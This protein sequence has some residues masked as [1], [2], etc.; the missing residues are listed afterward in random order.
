[1]KFLLNV[2][3]LSF[4]AVYN[5]LNKLLSLCASG[6]PPEG[7]VHRTFVGLP[8]LNLERLRTAKTLVDKAVR[9]SSFYR[10]HVKHLCGHVHFWLS[11]F[12]SSQT[13]K[14]FSVQG[15]YPVIRA[16]LKARGWVEQRKHRPNHH[17]HHR[18][19]DEG[20]DVEEG[21]SDESVNVSEIILLMSVDIPSL[22]Y[23]VPSSQIIQT[24]WKKSRVQMDYMISW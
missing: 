4:L 8:A 21:G 17:V 12:H 7:K 23:V 11:C 14:I 6:T 16:A 5:L 9:V 13:H 1:M 10:I 22:I 2:F 19:S 3:Q 15:P 24:M 20:S 18:H